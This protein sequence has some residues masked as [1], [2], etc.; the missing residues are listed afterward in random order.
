MANKPIS[1]AT[2]LA[3]APFQTGRYGGPYADRQ[4]YPSEQNY[5]AANP[6]VAG[7]ATEDGK[8][9]LNDFSGMSPRDREAVR[10]NELARLLMQSNPAY[11]PSFGSLTPQQSQ[12]LLSTTYADAPEQPRQET[13]A[14]RLFSG[15]PSG[16]T[17]TPEQSQFVNALRNYFGVLGAPF[18]FT[19]K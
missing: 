3:N 10:T 19:G 4:P 18:N 6:R 17:V 16:G 2:A 5:F 12:N 8:V 14:A 15:D 11:R 13:I 9:I 7:M 1:L